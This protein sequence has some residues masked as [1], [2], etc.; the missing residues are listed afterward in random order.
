MT[1]YPQTTKERILLAAADIFGRE[2][3]KATTIRR[4]AAEARA[5]VAAINY[6][7]R[8]KEGLYAEVLEDVFRTGFSKFPSKMG[9]ADDAPPDEQLR[10]F[11]RGMFYR[12][13]SSEGWGGV[14][15]KGRL[16]ARELLEPTPAFEAI[17]E[18]YIRPHKDL[19][20]GIIV[21][22]LGKNPGPMVLLPCAL[23]IIGQCIY[24]ALAGPVIQKITLENIPAEEN[25]ERLAEFVWLFS[26]GGIERIRHEALENNDNQIP[27]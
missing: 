7:F 25:L 9:I 19:L 17:L 6:H 21:A 8:D 1:E 13:L 14:A 3:F 18:K 12:L 16:I 23:S 5:N 10:G 15:G 2:G 24:Y 22:I 4:I 26:L 11:I 27:R 20:V